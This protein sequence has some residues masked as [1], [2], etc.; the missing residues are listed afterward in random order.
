MAAVPTHPSWLYRLGRRALGA[1]RYRSSWVE[2][3]VGPVHL[4]SR[5]GSGELPPVLLVHGFGDAALHWVPLVRAL[6]PHVRSV[7]ALDLPG[8]GF[9]HRPERLTL[10]VLRDGVI[11]ALDRTHAEP[12]VVVG[13]S[14]GG[15]VALRYTHARPDRVLGTHLISPGGAPMTPEELLAVRQLFAVRTF[16]EALA[17]LDKL[18]A[19]PLGWRGYLLAPSVR[20]TF[21]DPALHGLFEQITDAD[22]LT[23]DEVR[24]LSRPVRLL[25]GQRDKILP[26]RAL[27]FW[28]AHLPGHAELEEPDRFG[29]A[30]HFDSA[31]RIAEDIL[32]FVRRCAKAA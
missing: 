23:P 22:W 24:S 12:A 25:W 21:R 27:E 8:H 2:T 1:L 17:F 13:N 32:A 28:R 11:E 26:H 15:A 19:Y 6:R 29:H 14:L 3:S 7:I 9:S 20:S 10:D 5:Q 16:G 18:H 31:G 30:P 4:L